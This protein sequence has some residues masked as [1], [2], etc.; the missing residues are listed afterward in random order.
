MTVFIME[1]RITGYKLS[2]AFRRD[3]KFGKR[4][5]FAGSDDLGSTD[6]NAVIS[7]AQQMECTPEG[8]E[9]FSV[10]DRDSGQRVQI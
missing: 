3:P 6:I 4:T 9:L 2:D 10:T 5:F 7:A 1:Y 8:Y